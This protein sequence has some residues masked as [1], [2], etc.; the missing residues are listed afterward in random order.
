MPEEPH[1]FI[2]MAVHAFGGTVKGK[3]D[4]QKRIYFLGELTGRLAD[5]GYRPH[6]YGPYSAAVADGVGQLSS[7]GLLH[8]KSTRFGI[9]G[10]MGFEVCR[11]DYRLTPE[12]V[13]AAE[14]I[15][16]QSPEAWQK[17]KH[18]AQTMVSVKIPNYVILSVA[19]KAYCLLRRKGGKATYEGIIEEAK[20][21]G[22][23]ISPVQLRKAAG[24]LERLELIVRDGADAD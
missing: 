9:D 15:E 18:A 19:A 14:R 6:Y 23:A 21:L 22:W 16:K 5:L 20:K 17:I 11:H 7:I 10:Q 2:L 12:G 24:F 3:T 13:R 1:E 4:M 8:E